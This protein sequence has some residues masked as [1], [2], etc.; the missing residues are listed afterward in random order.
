MKVIK[1]SSKPIENLIK[2]EKISDEKSEIKTEDK[3]KEEK[4]EGEEKKEEKE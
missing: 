1:Y 3:V 2:I 4:L